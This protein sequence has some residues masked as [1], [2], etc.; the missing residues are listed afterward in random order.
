MSKVAARMYELA[1]KNRIPVIAVLELTWRCNLK[2][3][4]CYLAEKDRSR[5]GSET[6]ELTTSEWK[7][8]IAELA[9]MGCLYLTFSGGEVF[10]RQDI[11]ELVSYARNLAF[12]V[13]IFTNGTLIDDNKAHALSEAGV[14]RVE[15][16]LYGRAATHD[17][18]TGVSGSFER[19]LN[20][21]KTLKNCGV[22][23]GIKCPLMTFNFED[24]PYL[25]ELCEADG[26]R[27]M[28]DHTVVSGDDDS[29]HQIT[30]RI[31]KEQIKCAL[32]DSRLS[33][34]YEFE[35]HQP[36]P[37]RTF[38]FCAAGHTFLSVGPDGT[39]YPCVEWRKNMGN[40]K[41][42]SLEHIWRMSETAQWLGNLAEK[43]FT[44]CAS[45]RLLSHCP[46]CPG[47]ANKESG[48]PLSKSPTCCQL[49]QLN[50]EIAINS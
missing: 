21:L 28:F 16:S 9:E 37:P 45:C 20:A 32:R 27:Y 10:L 47:L 18:V 49:A 3:R 14:S 25:V 40:V 44:K 6:E 2:C 23:V 17:H 42:N 36:A 1:D 31:D 7:E 29:M 22:S 38:L 5:A 15:I 33:S 24:Y 13:S 8:V 11:V 41:T 35:G 4:H 12:D 39:I 19:S 26:F 50:S 46:R 43:D 30:Y 34:P 48:S